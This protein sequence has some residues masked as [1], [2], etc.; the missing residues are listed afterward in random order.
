MTKSTVH[1]GANDMEVINTGFL[2][3]E[4]L[5]KSYPTQNN[6]EFTVL[7]GINLTVGQDEYIS[8]NGISTVFAV[9]V[10]NGT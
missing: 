5:V 3:I 10:V 6:S 8:V 7:D 4:N 1:P 9:A 2:E